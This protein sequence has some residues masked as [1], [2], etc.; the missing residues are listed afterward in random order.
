MHHVTW[1]CEICQ[2]I[3][4]DALIGIHTV[5]ASAEA[6]MPTGTLVR[7]VRYCVDR[8]S[9]R[10]GAQQLGVDFVQFIRTRQGTEGGKC[11]DA[12]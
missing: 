11:Y 7:N 12:R 1:K 9:C 5:D 6:G 3:R 8:P 4:P 2:S 10:E